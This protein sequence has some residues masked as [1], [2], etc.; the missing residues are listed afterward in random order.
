[1]RFRKVSALVVA[2]VVSSLSFAQPED[3]YEVARNEHGQPDFQ[4]VWSTRFITPLEL[5]LIHI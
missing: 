3:T 1:M 4:G 5:S 2:L